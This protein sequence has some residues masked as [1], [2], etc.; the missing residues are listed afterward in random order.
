MRYVGYGGMTEQE[1]FAAVGDP[2]GWMKQQIALELGP[3]K[4]VD[5]L[6]R[7]TCPVCGKKM[8]NIYRREKMWQCKQCWDK[9]DSPGE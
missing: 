9:E 8:V 4:K 5:K 1:L 6:C 2:V 3:G 7:Q